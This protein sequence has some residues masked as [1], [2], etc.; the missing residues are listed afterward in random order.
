VQPGERAPFETTDDGRRTKD[1]GQSITTNGH[2]TSQPPTSNP[3]PPAPGATG[4]RSAHAR[5]GSRPS[6]GSAGPRSRAAAAP[7][8]LSS[9]ISARWRRRRQPASCAPPHSRAAWPRS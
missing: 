8:A 7:A 5:G 1:E 2:S 3:Q 9:A 4:R 6:L